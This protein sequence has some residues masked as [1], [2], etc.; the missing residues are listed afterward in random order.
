MN[1]Y[2]LIFLITIFFGCSS[3]DQSISND[4]KKAKRKL[5]REKTE[6]LFEEIGEKK[7][8]KS[9][10]KSKSEVKQTTVSDSVVSLY[11]IIVRNDSL[12]VFGES[13]GEEYDVVKNEAI[14]ALIDGIYIM[15]SSIIETKISSINDVYNSSY[16]ENVKTSN[17][18]KLFNLKILNLK[19]KEGEK[20]R[21][22]TYITKDDII[23]ANEE[24]EKEIK[25]LTTE[26]ENTFRLQE[27]LKDAVLI[28]YKAYLKSNTSMYEVKYYS[29]IKFGDVSAKNF[30]SENVINYLQDVKI[31]CYPT[32]MGDGKFKLDLIANYQGLSINNV[33]VKLKNQESY[34]KQFIDGKVS[35][36]TD[37]PDLSQ[38][39]F[40]I[41]LE[42][43]PALN[44][45]EGDNLNLIEADFKIV[46][47]KNIQ[48]DFSKFLSLDFSFQK[49]NESNLILIPSYKNFS[50]KDFYWEVD[51][52]EKGLDVVKIVGESPLISIPPKFNGLIAKLKLDNN[53]EFQVIKKIN[54]DF[55][56]KVISKPNFLIEPK[57]SDIPPRL[58][59]FV[60]VELRKAESPSNP[61]SNVSSTYYGKTD[62]QF[63][64]EFVLISSSD[65]LMKLLDSFRYSGKLIYSRDFK[66]MGKIDD[67][68]ILG[69]N[70]EKK[71]L[72]LKP[73]GEIRT[74]I[75][76]L[77][78]NF[79]DITEVIFYIKIL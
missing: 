60:S 5:Q 57:K 65:Q 69:Y 47:E 62:K 72:L 9:I 31:E 70:R 54:R 17:S 77:T 11:K 6:K 58:P 66:N 28:F 52:L 41:E 68:Y 18:M 33:K 30:S 55:S 20:F 64:S 53:D 37:Y 59:P 36:F 74:S 1:K 13:E 15:I 3:S 4:D 29:K 45:A 67:C 34:F 71:V 51:Y 21:I 22:F 35:L 42:I 63:E 39:T 78:I 56:L 32:D 8:E 16:L 40:L 10:V 46:V 50:I 14:K 7:I 73:G 61:T 49:V 38:K 23:K 44:M 19:P 25:L 79:D 75:K 2:F 43:S 27:N 48:V 12:Y 26:A 24:V 76:G